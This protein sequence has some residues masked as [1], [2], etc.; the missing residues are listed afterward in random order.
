MKPQFKRILVSREKTK[1]EKPEWEQKTFEDELLERTF[2]LEDCGDSCENGIKE[3][4]GKKVILSDTRGL[5][6]KE[7]ENTEYFILPQETVM[8][9]A[10][11]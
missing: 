8:C 3:L 4:K 7:F 2:T 10:S 1:S 9:E 6:V 5:K 11:N